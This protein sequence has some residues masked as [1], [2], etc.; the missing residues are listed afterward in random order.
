MA[1]WRDWTAV[2]DLMVKI[3]SNIEKIALGK[4]HNSSGQ[5]NQQQAATTCEGLA[6]WG[7]YLNPWF[8]LGAGLLP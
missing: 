7:A 6:Y 4:E 8:T 5:D 3:Q 1:V 2:E